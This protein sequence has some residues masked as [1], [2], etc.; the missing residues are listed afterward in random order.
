MKCRK[1]KKR[2]KI[3]KTKKLD[4]VIKRLISEEYDTFGG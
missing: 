3:R 1:G 4:I 2:K